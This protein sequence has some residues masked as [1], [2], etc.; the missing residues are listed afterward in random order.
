MRNKLV[1]SAVLLLFAAGVLWAQFWKNYSERDRQIV[2]QAYWLAGKQYQ[3]VGETDKGKEFQQLARIIDPQLDPS[4]I[5]DEAMPSAAELLARGNASVIGGGA[6]E[7]PAQSLNSFFFRYI[8]ALLGKDSTAA[9]GFLDGSVYLSRIST[10]ISREDAKTTLE[11]FFATAPLADKTPSELYNLDSIVVARVPDAMQTAWG[12]AYT[13]RVDAT[14]DYSQYLNFW[15]TKQQFFIR[16]VAGEW[17]IFAI[18]QNPPPLTWK[19]AQAAPV[20][21][22]PPSTTVAAE[23]EASKQIIAAFSGCLGALLKKDADGALGFM[24]DN[25]GF[26]RLRQTVTKEEL[27]TS[28]EGSFENADF[29]T[30]QVAD[31]VDLNSV[32]VEHAQ[33]PVAGVSGTAY[34]LSV[35]AKMDLSK[36]L[37]FWSTYQRYY[38][39]NDDG[40]WKIIALL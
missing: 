25:V 17:Y 8:G 13:L 1:L 12:N 14:A 11:Q 34:S 7:V 20:T 32:F 3:A 26:L 40:Q 16:S 31:A 9:S 23:A 27:K 6:T 33:S 4:A 39:V 38:F 36:S 24:S 18:G 29:G 37:P 22:A 21:S 35:Q 30:M 19:P 5:K 10:E 15:E 28:L 2:A